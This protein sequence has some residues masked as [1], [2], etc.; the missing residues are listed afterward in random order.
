METPLHMGTV[1]IQYLP[2]TDQYH[3]II[4]NREWLSEGDIDLIVE[5]VRDLGPLISRL[6][7]AIRHLTW[8]WQDLQIDVCPY[9]EEKCLQHIKEADFYLCALCGVSFIR[10]CHARHV[11]RCKSNRFTTEVLLGINDEDCEHNSLATTED[12]EELELHA[13]GAIDD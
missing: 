13:Y 11:I 5:L 2:A 8:F 1:V 7:K 3:L 12:L 4:G 6:S 9:C 10:D